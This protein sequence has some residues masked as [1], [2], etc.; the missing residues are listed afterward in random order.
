[1]SRDEIEFG[2]GVGINKLIKIRWT[3][4]VALLRFDDTAINSR[5][6]TKNDRTKS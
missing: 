4:V 5:N 2:I 3:P 6:S 1:M